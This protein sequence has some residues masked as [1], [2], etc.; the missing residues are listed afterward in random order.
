MKRKNILRSSL[1]L[2]LFIL[3]CACQEAT[4]TS[5]SNSEIALN[6]TT[7]TIELERY[8]PTQEFKDYWYAGEAEISSYR[9]EQARYGEMRDGQAVLV[10]VTEDFR[11]DTQVKADFKKGS[12]IP[13]LKLN[14]TKKFNT[15][16]YPY[17]IMQ[18]AFYPVSNNGHAI[19]L[20]CSVQEWCGQVFSQLNNRDQFETN[21]YS[22]FESEGD[23]S[24]KLE[25]SVLENEIWTQLRIDPTS[26]PTGEFDM[27]PSLEF[28]RLKHIELKAYE[29]IADRT[30]NT[31]NLVYP[32]LNRS[33]TIKFNPEFPFDINEWSETY[34]DG[35]GSGAKTL[36]TKATRM[37]SIKSAYWSKN[38]NSDE[39]LRATL[40][41]R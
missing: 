32:E 19:K 18:S 20:S 36:T 39:V 22:Y 40:Q 7:E 13:V 25:K 27:M 9:L 26:L 29:V 15:G 2:S 17:S 33:L 16:I 4:N 10:F 41:L 37:K 5:I 34:K 31:Y 35:Y 12:D 3:L 23:E 14:S 8:K 38:S 28:I 24:L 6:K 21:S 30:D 1:Q 11:A